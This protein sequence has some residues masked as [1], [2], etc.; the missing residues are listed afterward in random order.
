MRVLFLMPRVCWPP[1]TGLMLRNY[2]LARAV[3]RSCEVV[4]LSFADDAREVSAEE[5]RE[6][7]PPPEKWCERVELV[8]RTAGYTPFKLLRGAVGSKPVTVLN[9]TTE[10]MKTALARLLDE[11]PCDVAQVET[12]TLGDYL[13]VLRAAKNRPRAVCDWHNI[14]SELMLR[15]SE[16]AAFPRNFYARLTARRIAAFERWTLKNYDAHVACSE[17]DAAQ[18]RA[19]APGARVSVIENGVDVEFYSDAQ[20]ARAHEIWRRE[21]DIHTPNFKSRVLYVGSMDYHA[22]I[23]AVTDFALNDW[24]DIHRQRPELSFTIVGRRPAPAV[25]ALTELPGV[26][27][28]GTVPDVRP[29]YHEA[30]AQIVPLR[31]G[32]GSRLKILEA[33]AAGVPVIS[34]RLGAEGL[35]VTDGQDIVLADDAETTARGLFAL[36]DDEAKRRALIDAARAL[37]VAQ[38]DW[39]ALGASLYETHRGL[40]AGHV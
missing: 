14:D 12:S 27:V 13:P 5:R 26:E 31:V 32:S 15:Y 7:P 23:D 37:V 16:K 22:N 2:H 17:R 35:A 6:L 20:L 21:Q 34:T 39:S 36:I 30:A 9:Y 11:K 3:A 10:A 19:V 24:P 1:Q 18:L 8:E 4:C 40:S 38:Y 29:Y 33:M 25:L 28:T